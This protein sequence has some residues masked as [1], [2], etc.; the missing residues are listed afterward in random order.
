MSFSPEKVADLK[1]KHL[2]MLQSL[3]TRTAG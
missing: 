1:V 3:I 2:E